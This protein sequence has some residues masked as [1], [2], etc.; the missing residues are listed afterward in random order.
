MVVH[1][2]SAD[3]RSYLWLKSLVR[4]LSA[5]Q[6]TLL[7]FLPACML[8][9]VTVMGKEARKMTDLTITST[10]FAD[11]TAIPARYTC[12]GQDINPPLTFGAVPAGAKSLALIVDDPDAPVGDWVHWLVWNIPPQVREIRENSVPGGAVQG[13]NDWKRNRYGG[14]C[15]PGGTHRYFFKLYALDTSLNLAATTTK[16]ALE[17]ALEGH[18]IAKRELM[19][20]YRRK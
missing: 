11:K 4:F 14:P 19:G 2:S 7:V 8:M 6:L 10:A 20:T 15:P 3:I 17:H 12:D 13:L 18:V 16:S 1:I 9:P 5:N